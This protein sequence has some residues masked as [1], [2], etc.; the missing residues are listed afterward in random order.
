MRW[1]RAHIPTLRQD[2][3]EADAPSHRLLL[4][5]GYIRQLSAG[6]YSYLPLA[7]RVRE[8]V[9]AIIR[10]EMNNVGGQ[11]V[12]MPVMHPAALWQRTGRTETVDILFRF[13]DSRGQD[14]VLAPT[15]EESITEMARD[16]HSYKDLP[17]LWYQFQI[18]LR[19]EKRPKSG[20][21]RVREFT[22]KDA[23][24]FDIDQAG[25]DKS[26]NDNFAAYT[27]IFRRLGFNAIPVI[28]SSGAMGGSGSIEFICPSETGEDE[29]AYCGSC[30][31]AANL[32]TATSRLGDIDD[33]MRGQSTE[34]FDTPGI[35]TCAA[36]ESFSGISPARSIKTLVYMLDGAMTLVLLRGDHDLQEQKLFDATGSTSVRPAHPDEIREALGASPGSLGAVGVH[37][38]PVLADFA[39]QGRYNLITG[40]NTDD[41]HVRNVDI[42]RD[43]TVKGWHD[44]RAVRDEER[45]PDC[46]EAYTIQRGIEAGH[47]FKLGCKYTEALDISVL[48]PDGRAMRPIMGCYG[49]GVERSIA[50][51]VESNHDEKGIIWP[52]AI[53]PYHVD[54]IPLNADND[55]VMGAASILYEELSGG[56]I[57]TIIDDRDVRAGV[58]LADSELI[59]FPIRIAIGTRSIAERKVEITI[60]RTGKTR[61]VPLTD[62]ADDVDHILSDL[63]AKNL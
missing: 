34:V 41:K 21:L 10:E 19:D 20:L 51:A 17:Q 47:I 49:I 3:L 4:R 59:G 44:F 42:D 14:M 32:E 6:H 53:A 24:S 29:I 33:G 31:Y 56:G 25:L 1:S 54:V 45:C 63:R 61:S 62:A 2:P 13:R 40:A 30:G 60:R 26:F 28:A 57:D 55:E 52:V 16:L 38:I 46:G 12:M 27:N 43:I 5:A 15:H 48:G 18:K 23:Y 39:L 22:M 11:E 8:K 7:L 9:I 36:L 58:K 50:I 37:H 35:Y